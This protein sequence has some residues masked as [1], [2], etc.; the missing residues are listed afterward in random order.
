[1]QLQ[2]SRD[3]EVVICDAV[4]PARFWARRQGRRPYLVPASRLRSLAPD[5]YSRQLAAPKP[6]PT[7]QDEAVGRSL[8]DAAAVAVSDY[9]AEILGCRSEA[10]LAVTKFD[11]GNRHHVYQASYREPTGVVSHLVVRVSYTADPAERAAAQREA[12]VLT[13][14]CGIAG[15]RLIDFRVQS[16]W[17]QAPAMCIEFVPG[18]ERELRTVGL[19]EME[20]LGS[21]VGWLHDQ[22]VDDLAGGFDVTQSLARYAKGR[23][24]SIL[25]RLSWNREPLPAAVQNRL[26]SVAASV[27][28]AGTAALAGPSFADS[29]RLVLLHGDIADGNILWGDGPKL[30]DWEYAR[31]GDPAD[32]I[33]Y[34]FDQN[35]LDASRRDAFWRGYRPILGD[36]AWVDRVAKR[37]SW[38]ES[39]TLLGSTLWWVERWVRRSLA[40]A[41]RKADPIAPRQVDYYRD[42]ALSR[43][44][45]LEGLLP[46]G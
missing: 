8:E 44:D 14:A 26:A 32:E 19:P 36:K 43:L 4:A 21:L 37:V 13:R 22:P 12:A 5:P 31:V 2:W 35:G 10:L 24:D 23:L 46:A 42:R 33:A 27:Q 9:V 38:W 6:V 15:P 25:A 29:D 7:R 20:Q 41:G 3:A 18:V 11:A 28:K 30:I 1:M 34:T 40:D 39:L 17:F 16:A 45:R